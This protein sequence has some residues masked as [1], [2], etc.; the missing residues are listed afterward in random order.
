MSLTPAPAVTP[1]TADSIDGRVMRIVHAVS[2]TGS[3]TA[4]AELLHLSQPAVSQQIKNAETRLGIPLV[5]RVGRGVRLTEAGGI[6]ARHARVITAELEGAVAEISDLVGLRSGRLR[7]ASFPSASAVIVPEL[8]QSIRHSHPGLTT[9]Y[10]ELEP[11]Q[12]I[13]AVRN[14]ELDAALTFS[15]PG[16][17]VGLVGDT[18]PGLRIEHLW[19]EEV[20]VALPADHPL[21][22][23]DRVRLND[24]AE[25]TW[26]AGCLRCRGHLVAAA[27]SSGFI[28][29]ISHETDNMVAVMGM[30]AASF[31]VALVPQLSVLAAKAFPSRVVLLPIE[32]DTHRVISLVS[33]LSASDVPAITAT[34]AACRALDPAAWSLTPFAAQPSLASAVSR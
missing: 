13:E 9:H 21:A 29:R 20:R 4:A 24:L 34:R 31:A 7:L 3:I 15:Y 2:V 6:L 30:V 19:R 23:R 32:G 17:G 5:E 12:A 16:D 18:L 1:P 25:D 14:G 33:P 26:I 22:T 27:E 8:L 28:P 10:R 11:P